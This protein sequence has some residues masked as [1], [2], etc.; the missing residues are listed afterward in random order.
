MSHDTTNY[1]FYIATIITYMLGTMQVNMLREQTTYQHMNGVQNTNKRGL[2][3]IIIV[4]TIIIVLIW[5]HI[6]S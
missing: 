6:L 5:D 1:C 2:L 4:T 3:T